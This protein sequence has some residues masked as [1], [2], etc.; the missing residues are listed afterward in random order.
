MKPRLLLKIKE[1]G[2]IKYTGCTKSQ[3]Y[4]YEVKQPFTG[5]K[6]MAESL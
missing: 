2:S 5:K 3:T 6:K 4:D 1:G